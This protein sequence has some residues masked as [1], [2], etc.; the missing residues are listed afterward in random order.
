MHPVNGLGCVHRG[1]VSNM[2][3][4]QIQG[5][6]SKDN[7][8][9]FVED[10]TLWDALTKTQHSPGNPTWSSR[11]VDTCKAAEGNFFENVPAEAF[12]ATLRT[13][14]MSTREGTIY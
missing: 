7:S 1:K 10:K 14:N 4:P 2:A 13:G 11:L 8:D 6:Q 5:L 9:V 12:I 3:R